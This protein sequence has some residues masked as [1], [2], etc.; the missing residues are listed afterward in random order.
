LRASTKF[1]AALQSPIPICIGPHP[2]CNSQNLYR[3]HGER[4]RRLKLTVILQ[5]CWLKCARQIQQKLRCALI[6]RGRRNLFR[7][8]TAV[9]KRFDSTVCRQI[10]FLRIAHTSVWTG[11][12]HRPRITC[13]WNSQTKR[14]HSQSQSGCLVY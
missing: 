4:V 6:L 14:G 3:L 2:I 12:H 1:Q 5:A 11:Y 10:V 8:V 9:S 13:D 7:T